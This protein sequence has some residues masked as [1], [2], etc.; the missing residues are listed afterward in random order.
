MEQ[1]TESYGISLSRIH[2]G[3]QTAFKEYLDECCASKEWKAFTPDSPADISR[4]VQQ[5]RSLTE[6]VGTASASQAPA[7]FLQRYHPLSKALPSNEL[8]CKLICLRAG[9]GKIRAHTGV[10]ERI[11]DT[12]TKLPYEARLCQHCSTHE[13]EDI[14]HAFLRCTRI[15][16]IRTS[17]E[18]SMAE[19]GLLTSWQTLTAEQR[20]S[21]LLFEVLP[22]T[23]LWLESRADL[24]L[25]ILSH[26]TSMALKQQHDA[27]SAR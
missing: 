1:R 9:A 18:N 17:C 5:Y 7:R 6:A 10:R 8:T 27:A 24:L 25:P 2:T 3:R 21:L 15:L 4:A 26:W 16:P 20:L 19:I 11:P 12:T 14:G 13:V 22:S 23:L